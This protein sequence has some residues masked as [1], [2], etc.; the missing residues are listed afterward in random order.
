[1]RSWRVGFWAWVV[2]SECEV[3]VFVF[4]FVFVLGSCCSMAWFFLSPTHTHT[5]R[6]GVCG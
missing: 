3:V 6:E 2:G 4:V 5:Q 1:M